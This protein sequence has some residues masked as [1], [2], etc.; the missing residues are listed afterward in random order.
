MQRFLIGLERCC[1]RQPSRH[2]WSLEPDIITELS[3]YQDPSHSSARPD[4]WRM[5]HY[6][7][8]V[9][10]Y[11]QRK[12]TNRAMPEN[13][14][15]DP[16]WQRLYRAY[17]DEYRDYSDGGRVMDPDKITFIWAQIIAIIPSLPNLKTFRYVKNYR[18]LHSCITELF[19]LYWPSSDGFRQ[20]RLQNPLL[21]SCVMTHRI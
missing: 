12:G 2:P 19:N 8:L 10:G 21:T 7:G 11:K 9:N 20:C 3:F 14:Q 18:I 16:E 15:T 4:A 6:R 17:V 1:L 13:F 5:T